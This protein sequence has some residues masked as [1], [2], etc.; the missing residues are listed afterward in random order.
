MTS[1]ED[2]VEQR[3]A[4]LEVANVTPMKRYIGFARMMRQIRFASTD[5]IIDHPY[6]IAAVDEQVDHM[7]ADKPGSAS[8]NGNLGVGCHFAPSFFI[9]LTL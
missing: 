3:S 4:R 6:L 7:A 1:V 8:N 5:E 2:A 9:V